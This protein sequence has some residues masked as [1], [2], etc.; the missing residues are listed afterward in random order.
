MIDAGLKLLLRRM[1]SVTMAIRS[2]VRW[3]IDIPT[4]RTFLDGGRLA[5]GVGASQ[6]VIAGKQQ[7]TLA[8]SS[9]VWGL[10]FRKQ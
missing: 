2:S 5:D 8:N 7:S 3:T 1:I 4:R 10:I 9:L 6:S